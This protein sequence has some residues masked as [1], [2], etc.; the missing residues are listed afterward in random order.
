M[1]TSPLHVIPG[2]SPRLSTDE[3][4][5]PVPTPT[6]TIHIP[7][8]SPD[9]EKAEDEV[10]TPAHHE[11]LDIEHA[12]VENDPRAWSRAKKVRVIARSFYSNLITSKPNIAFRFNI[13]IWRVDDRWIECERL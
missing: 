10:P 9:L 6:P 5:S 13:G 4:L 3:I 8:D 7:T 11:K 2:P 1:S 12:H